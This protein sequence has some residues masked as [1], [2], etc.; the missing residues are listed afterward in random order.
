MPSVYSCQ[1]A[2]LQG[3][4][5]YWAFQHLTCTDLGSAAEPLFWS[6]A[7]F[8]ALVSVSFSFPCRHVE[9]TLGSFTCRSILLL[10]KPW[11][12][13]R[14]CFLQIW[15][16]RSDES[17]THRMVWVGGGLEDHLVASSLPWEGTSSTRPN[18]SR[19]YLTWFWTPTGMGHP[20][21]LWATCFLRHNLNILSV[22]TEHSHVSCQYML[23]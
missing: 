14:S 6:S 11:D 1:K 22:W 21:L 13:G 4:V 3:S 7:C 23:L 5:G 20:H 15:D 16:Y 17:Q 12:G 2:V 18:C 9:E 8:A 19:S 10:M